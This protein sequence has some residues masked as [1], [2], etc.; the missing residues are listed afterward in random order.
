MRIGG[1]VSAHTLPSTETDESGGVA[2]AL[3]RLGLRSP[4]PTLGPLVRLAPELYEL[5]GFMDAAG[6]AEMLDPAHVLQVDRY[7]SREF[8]H[9]PAQDLILTRH[10]GAVGAPDFGFIDQF[11][12]GGGTA[13]PRS[14][15]V[16]DLTADD[17][18]DWHVRRGAAVERVAGVSVPFCHYGYRAFGHFVLDGLLQ[19]YLFAD[20]IDQGRAKVVHWPFEHAWMDELLETC[21]VGPGQ[22][23]VLQSPVALLR[24]ARVSSAL[25]AH[26]VYFPASYSRGFFQWLGAKLGALPTPQASGRVYVRR[27]E[28]HSRPVVNQDALEALLAAHGF[29]VLCAHTSDIVTQARAIAQS[30]IMI[31]AWGSGLTLAPLLG[32]RRQVVELTPTTV[33]DP[34]FLR[35]AVVHDLRY[36]PVPH[37]PHEG[38]GLFADLERIERIVAAL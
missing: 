28:G 38:E 26:G 25:A 15:M 30:E 17:A 7:E 4:R 36:M 21:G 35:Q 11:N 18:G 22:R 20:L 33:I 14:L 6:G 29:Q 31:S 2:E 19:V 16:H 23:R 9:G 12:V 8:F 27:S 5:G 13:L 10:A 3:W 1:A 37:P 32:G 24:R 34:W